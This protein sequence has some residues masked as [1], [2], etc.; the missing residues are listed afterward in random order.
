[1][2]V[3]NNSKATIIYNNWL[4]KFFSLRTLF[5]KVNN[6]FYFAVFY[7]KLIYV[8]FYDNFYDN[9]FIVTR[10]SSSLESFFK[11][12]ILSVFL[13]LIEIKCLNMIEFSAS[14]KKWVKTTK[15][16]RYMILKTSFV[17]ITFS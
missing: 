14:I 17:I 3:K 6:V 1:M 5:L 11:F 10:Y 8:I 15:H 16:F 4:L 12:L 13:H 2:H 9:S 7:K